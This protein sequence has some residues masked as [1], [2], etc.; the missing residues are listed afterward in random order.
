MW[1][2]VRVAVTRIA[3]RV[4]PG[5]SRRFVGGTYGETDRLIVSVQARAVDGKATIAVI[6]AVAEA[7]AV[8]KSQVRLVSGAIARDKVLEIEGDPQVIAEKLVRLR[9]I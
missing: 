9:E 1:Q 8:A 3:I 5:S 6:E 7:F 2:G 4:K